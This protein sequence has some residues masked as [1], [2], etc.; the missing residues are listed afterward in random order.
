MY[1]RQIQWIL[2]ATYLSNVYLCR[3]IES[4]AFPLPQ[5]VCEFKS[6]RGFFPV[7][8]ELYC[9]YLLPWCTT[10]MAIFLCMQEGVTACAE[11]DVSLSDQGMAGGAV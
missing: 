7:V 2:P 9:I 8:V 10:P 5:S 3:T 6:Q 11:E 1:E 4:E